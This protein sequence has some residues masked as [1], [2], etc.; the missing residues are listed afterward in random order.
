MIL[1]GLRRSDATKKEA[2]AF[3]Q[4]TD[5][6]DKCSAE[7]RTLSYLLHPPLLDEIGLASA[8]KWYVEGFSERS[9][10]EVHLNLQPGL[11]RLPSA[12]ELVLFRVLQETL[13]NIHR[14]TRSR[15]VDIRLELAGENVLLQVRDYGQGMPPALLEHSQGGKGAGVGLRSIRERISEIGGRLEI[16]SNTKGTL[17]QVIAPLSA[18]ATQ[19]KA[20]V[21]KASGA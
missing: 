3:Q 19:S 10:I 11:E 16:Q 2:Q 1:E 20:S 5:T 12:L 6:L 18:G 17:I 8:A 14:H 21:G 15:S 9:G 4:L 7:T 13:T